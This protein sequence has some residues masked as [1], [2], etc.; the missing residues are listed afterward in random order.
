MFEPHEILRQTLANPSIFWTAFSGLATLLAVLFALSS[1]KRLRKDA[2]RRALAVLPALS[3]EMSEV[4]RYIESAKITAAAAKA[5]RDKIR[6]ETDWNPL[7]QYLEIDGFGNAILNKTA[8]AEFHS[9]VSFSLIAWKGLGR[10][11][12]GLTLSESQPIFLCYTK[13]ERHRLSA[14]ARLSTLTSTDKPL[15]PTDIDFYLFEIC[16]MWDSAVTLMDRFSLMTGEVVQEHWRTQLPKR[17]MVR[18]LKG[19]WLRWRAKQ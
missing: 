19:R 11:L 13:L 8:I 6:T 16:L 7:L 5:C 14:M 18:R 1:A 15:G 9:S 3:N 2:H 12:D 10:Y 4:C 17:T